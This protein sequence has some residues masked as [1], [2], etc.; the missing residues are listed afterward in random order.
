MIASFKNSKYARNMNLFSRKKKNVIVLGTDGMLGHD[1]VELLMDEQ[2][3]A[4]SCIGIVTPLTSKDIDIIEPFALSE[5][6]CRNRINPPVK[7]DYVINCA[8]MT[9]TKKIE[10]DI[11]Y[12]NKAYDVNALS[13][14]HIANICAINKIKL[15]HISTDYVFSQFSTKD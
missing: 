9:D 8:A 10:T 6:V 13:L 15:I 14:K 4:Q 11:T 7:Y 12:R 5:H 2:Q 3:K 1:V